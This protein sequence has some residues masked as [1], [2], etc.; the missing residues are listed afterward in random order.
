MSSIRRAV[1]WLVQ[2]PN[3]FPFIEHHAKIFRREDQLLDP[4][5]G[6]CRVGRNDASHGHTCDGHEQNCENK[7]LH[8]SQSPFPSGVFEPWTLPVRDFS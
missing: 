1:V 3:P 7:F 2:E 8:P 4:P 5:R 6:I